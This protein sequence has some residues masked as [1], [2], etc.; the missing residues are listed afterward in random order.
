MS[1]GTLY[2]VAVARTDVSEEH[3]SPIFRVLRLESSQL[4]P[5]ICLTTDGEEEA[6]ATTNQQQLHSNGST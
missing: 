4:I 5:R 3:I 6:L 1:P 2:R